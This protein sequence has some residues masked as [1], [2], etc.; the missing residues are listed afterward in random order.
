MN[1]LPKDEA[2]ELELRGNFQMALVVDVGIA[3]CLAGSKR[4]A[5]SFLSEKGA[6]FRVT[7]RV[8]SE[9]AQRRKTNL[10]LPLRRSEFADV[11]KVIEN[12]L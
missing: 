1:K 11:A 6:N 7:V 9:P 5:A 10:L 12:L 2:C 4:A 3:L 8:I